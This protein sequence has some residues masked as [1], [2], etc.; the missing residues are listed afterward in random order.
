MLRQPRVI[1]HAAGVRI[2][3]YTRTSAHTHKHPHTH[4]HTHTHTCAQQVFHRD[5]EA[6][7]ALSMRE[8]HKATE[9]ADLLSAVLRRT[10]T[11]K[12][13]VYVDV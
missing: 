12:L 9:E 5:A 1:K 3:I 10:L 2:H 11:R 13:Q 7:E 8:L 4:R 6:I